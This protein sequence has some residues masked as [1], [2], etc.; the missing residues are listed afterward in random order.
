MKPCLKEVLAPAAFTLTWSPNPERS[1]VRGWKT[2]LLKDKSHSSSIWL[3]S[4]NAKDQSRSIIS[5]FVLFFSFLK[6]KLNC[7]VSSEL[8]FLWK[9]MCVCELHLWDI[10]TKYYDLV[11][12]DPAI[13]PKHLFLVLQPL[14]PLNT[15]V[16]CI[17]L[18]V[19]VFAC[20]VHSLTIMV[21]MKPLLNGGTGSPRP[22]LTLMRIGKKEKR[23]MDVDHITTYNYF[24]PR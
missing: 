20:V 17:Y 12:D 2:L 8:C 16:T 18:C 10:F 21:R 14:Q 4:Q 3:K 1:W 5:H 9:C 11:V 24:A 6:R 7:W 15:W 22:T 23:M 19:C 13:S